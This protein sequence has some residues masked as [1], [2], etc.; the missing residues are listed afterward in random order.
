L[1]IDEATVRFTLHL[2]ESRT[3]TIRNTDVVAYL[4]ADQASP[5]ALWG[6]MQVG[7]GQ[8]PAKLERTDRKEIDRQDGV[9]PAPGDDDLRRFNQTKDLAKQKVILLGMLDKFGDT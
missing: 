5:K 2:R 1:R 4:P 3:D 6:S 7:E 9:A 8:Y